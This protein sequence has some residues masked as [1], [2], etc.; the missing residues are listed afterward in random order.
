M[1]FDNPTAIINFKAYKESTGSKAIELAIACER[2]AKETG[3]SIIIA[4]H[5]TDVRQ[6]ASQVSIPVLCQHADPVPMGAYTGWMP[7]ALVKEMGAKGILINHSEHKVKLDVLKTTVEIAR[8]EGLLIVLCA[9]TPTE[10][11]LMAHLKPDYVAI[12]PPE[13]IGGDISVSN[14]KPE[15]I[16]ESVNRVRKIGRI[17]VLCGAGVKNAADVKK[18]VELGAKGILVAS[19]VT[20]AKD[21]E[22]AIRDLLSGFR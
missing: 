19:G 18:A 9:D 8:K 22:A 4:V 20:K 1:N 2:V 11:E 5:P 13:L 10:I 14:A 12:E 15:V 6:I 17:P 21:P 7:P 3:K 16:T